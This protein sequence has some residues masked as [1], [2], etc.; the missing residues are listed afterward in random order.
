MGLKVF[1]ISAIT[2]EAFP[3][4][5]V[6]VTLESVVAAANAAEPK[7]TFLIKQLIEGIA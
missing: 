1:A 4:V 3:E 2:D 6:S 5:P 7:M